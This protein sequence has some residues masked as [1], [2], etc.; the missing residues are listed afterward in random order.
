[1]QLQI[2][3]IEQMRIKTHS[4]IGV[5]LFIIQ[6]IT[7]KTKTTPITIIIIITMNSKLITTMG[8]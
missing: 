4:K 1:M 7:M 5:L 6:Q 2:E 8:I 3:L